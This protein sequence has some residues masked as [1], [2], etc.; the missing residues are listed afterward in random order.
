MENIEEKV[1][2]LRDLI[3]TLVRKE[4]SPFTESEIEEIARKA[5]L[6]GYN[7]TDYVLS[8]TYEN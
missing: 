2:E 6:G 8:R 3:Y 5:L 4:Q 1:C 7:L